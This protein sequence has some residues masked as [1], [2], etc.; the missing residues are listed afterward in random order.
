M[1][2]AF[3]VSSTQILSWSHITNWYLQGLPHI[4]A[5]RDTLAAG[6]DELIWRRIIADANL[7]VLRYP[8]L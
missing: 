8:D 3:S 2:L 4:L 6:M 7:S 1:D 5:E